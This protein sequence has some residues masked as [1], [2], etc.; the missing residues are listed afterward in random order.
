MIGGKGAAQLKR[1]RG[2]D[3]DVHVEIALV[4][5]ARDILTCRVLRTIRTN[6]LVIWQLHDRQDS[7][8]CATF[9]RAFRD[10]AVDIPDAGS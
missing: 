10:Q 2:A 4:I 1:R 6:Q 8:E 5:T 3:E 7:M 9:A